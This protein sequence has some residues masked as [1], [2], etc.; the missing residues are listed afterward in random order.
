MTPDGP[1]RKKRTISETL[2]QL[3]TKFKSELQYYQLVLKH[4]GTPWVPKAMLA[5]AVAY[6]ASPIDL[7]PD[8][9]PVI[10]H[11]DDLI[12]IPC[13]LLMVTQMIPENV[14]SECRKT[15]EKKEYVIQLAC[16]AESVKARR[17]ALRYYGA[18]D[19]SVR[20]SKVKKGASP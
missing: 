20:R 3:G 12:I 13:I 2:K 4:P 8:F 14:K 19:L 11:L 16:A 15:V 17:F 18:A 9:V 1:A 7:I 6:A 10:G 5:I